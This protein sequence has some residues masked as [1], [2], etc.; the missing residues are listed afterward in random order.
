[1]SHV[2]NAD[3]IEFAGLAA[4]AF[5]GLP[6]GDGGSEVAATR[7]ALAELGLPLLGVP[8]DAGGA[9]MT[10]LDLV[11]ILEEAGYADVRVAIAE[12]VGVVAPLLARH[13]TPEQRNT[14]FPA[15]A[16]GTA[17]GTGYCP[18]RGLGSRTGADI[19]LAEHDGRVLLL[20]LREVTGAPPPVADLVGSSLASPLG[21]EDRDPEPLV[22]EL[23]GRGA[24]VAAAVLNGITRRLLD[25][26]LDHVRIREQ[27]GV[28]I[29][30]FQAVRHML[31]EVASAL[32]FARAP[33]WTAARC[34]AEDAP[35]TE[36]ATHVAKATAARAGALA[37]DHALQ[38]HGGIGFTKEHELHRWLLH[39]HELE[40]RWGTATTHESALG[41]VGLHCDSLVTEFLP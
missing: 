23:A 20:D 24:W 33:A 36:L 16:Q 15:L 32:E 19:A 26:S 8:E 39:G 4:K 14:W 41:R 21:G 10:E 35:G 28:P 2:F 40:G 30:T 38:V 7:A 31:A 12:T 9:G 11:L 6:G 27:F 5:A 1:M 22:R 13:G 17:L 25:L 3:Q 37:N 34:L 18:V 29:G